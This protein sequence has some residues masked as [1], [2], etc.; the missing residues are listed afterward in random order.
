MMVG[1]I[2]VHDHVGRLLKCLLSNDVAKCINW[3]GKNGKLS[4]SALNLKKVIF[5]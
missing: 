2:D 3:T 1:G 5:G 4:F